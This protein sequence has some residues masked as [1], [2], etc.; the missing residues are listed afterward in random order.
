MH[1]KE[2]ITYRKHSKNIYILNSF[3]A[4]KFAAIVRI[5]EDPLF[6]KAVFLEIADP[7]VGF[8]LESFHMSMTNN[9]QDSS[10]E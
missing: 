9:L 5:F 8:V 7:C 4:E 6:F 2:N 1:Q 10:S 3:L